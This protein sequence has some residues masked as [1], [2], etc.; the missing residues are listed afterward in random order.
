MIFASLQ[1]N[2]ERILQKQVRP[3]AGER[4]SVSCSNFHRI[5]QNSKTYKKELALKKK[6]IEKGLIGKCWETHRDDVL[7]LKEADGISEKII[8]SIFNGEDSD[9]SD[10]EFPKAPPKKAGMFKI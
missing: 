3:S 6:L 4:L 2:A 8:R 5:F 7:D 9:D 10:T 1:E